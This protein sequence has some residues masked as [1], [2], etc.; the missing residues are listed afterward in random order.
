MGWAHWIGQPRRDWGILTKLRPQPLKL[1]TCS[2][3]SAGLRADPLQLDELITPRSGRWQRQDGAN[4]N[5]ITY[6]EGAE[7]R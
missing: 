1:S 2:P 3:S 6:L 7:H 4:L 5:R